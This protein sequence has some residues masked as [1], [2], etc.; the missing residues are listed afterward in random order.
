MLRLTL[1]ASDSLVTSPLCGRCPSGP[2]GCCAAPPALAWADLG[3]IVHHGGTAWLLAE[4][5]AGRLHPCPRGLAIRRVPGPHGIACTYLGPTGCTLL[6]DRRAVT[7]NEYLCDDAY[8]E[9]ERAGDPNA[10]RGRAAHSVLE[11]ALAAWDAALALEVA[12]RGAPPAFNEAFFQW[13]GEAFL[14][15]VARAPLPAELA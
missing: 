15:A 10:P 8:L 12:G 1:A 2:A 6:P 14:R 5:D 13:L 11:P 4:L 3:R 7:C 9:A